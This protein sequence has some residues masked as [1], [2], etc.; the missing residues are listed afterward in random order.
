M[1]HRVMSLFS[2]QVLVRCPV[3]IGHVDIILRLE[4]FRPVSIAETVIHQVMLLSV[5]GSSVVRIGHVDASHL[6]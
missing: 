5:S 6:T 2:C 3:A 4:A 1:I